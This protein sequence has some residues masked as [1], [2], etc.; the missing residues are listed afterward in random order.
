MAEGLARAMFADTAEIFSAGS[1]PT[2]VNPSA[3]TAM[4]EIGID[5]SSH[6]S[7]AVADINAG[8]MDLI[9]TLCA[10]EVCP[11]VPGRVERLHWPLPDPAGAPPA[12]ALQ[13][14]RDVR[15]EIQRR[16]IVLG[17]ERHLR[18]EASR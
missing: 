12:E 14:F 11:V 8:S 15:D 3:I 13:K 4:A 18:T 1:V 9:I 10:D 6:T 5:I 16:L 7:K 2:H 17:G